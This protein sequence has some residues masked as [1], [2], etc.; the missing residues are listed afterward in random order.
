MNVVLLFYP[1]N[2]V[3]ALLMKKH[4]GQIFSQV[5]LSS[6][7]KYLLMVPRTIGQ[8]VAI[9]RTWQKLVPTKRNSEKYG[10]D[11]QEKGTEM[12]WYIYTVFSM[13]PEVLYMH[14]CNLN[15]PHHCF[16]QC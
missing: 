11:G 1:G 6:D 16:H 2:A 13:S 4:E 3:A 12:K 8:E 7:C 5:L 14:Y 10:Q 9:Q 15:R